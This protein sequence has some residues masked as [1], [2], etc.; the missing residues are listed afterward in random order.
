MAHKITV[1][2][3]A[4]GKPDHVVATQA[5]ATLSIGDGEL[6]IFVGT[7]VVAINQLR[8]ISALQQLRDALRENLFPDGA[9]ADNYAYVTPPDGKPGIIVGNAAAIPAL[10]EDEVAIA[11][12]G[13]FYSE[14]NSTLF[15]NHIDRLIETFQEKILKSASTGVHAFASGVLTGTTIVATNTVTINSRVY[16]FIAVPVA[17]DDID[18]GSDDSESLDNLIAAINAAAG[19]GTLYGTGTVIN[20]DARAAAGAGDTMDVVAR[21]SGTAGNAIT[22]TAVLSAG[23][24]AAATLLGG[25]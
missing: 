17:A 3:I 14:S 18:V 11:Y 25:L 5:A 10:T 7:G 20:P 12:G 9:S 24:F 13:T 8:C 16:T 2:N 15:A 4:D 6:G 23:N 22:T 19:E 21:I 1:T